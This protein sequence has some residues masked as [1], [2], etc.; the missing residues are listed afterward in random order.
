MTL[1]MCWNGKF[2]KRCLILLALCSLLSVILL[3]S[4]L[5]VGFLSGLITNGELLEQDPMC[6][7]PYLP[8]FNPEVMK[9]IRKVE[10]ITCGEAE[11]DWVKSNGTHAFLTDEAKSKFSPV[12]CKFNG[13]SMY[14]QR[15][16]KYMKYKYIFKCMCKYGNSDWSKIFAELKTIVLN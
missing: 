1:H 2:I 15:Q 12:T 8:I 9:H 3:S 14:A 5:K 13:G 7:L 11:D 16:M 4:R 10:Q 6:K